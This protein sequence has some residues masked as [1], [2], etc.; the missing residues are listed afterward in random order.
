MPVDAWAPGWFLR[1]GVDGDGVSVGV[2]ERELEAEGSLEWFLRNGHAGF[3]EA[4]VYSGRI[5]V[6]EPHPDPP[7]QWRRIE[8]DAGERF[9]HGEGHSV[10]GGEDDCGRGGDWESFQPDEVFVEASGCRRVA[11]LE[12]DKRGTGGGHGVILLSCRHGVDVKSLTLNCGVCQTIDMKD[13]DQRPK[14][15]ASEE[16]GVLIKQTQA[17]LNQRMD[18]VLRPLGLSV[19]QY[20]CLQALHDSPGI[21]G[22]ELARRVFV[23]RQSTSVLLHG[24]EKRGLIV[25]AEDPGPRRERAMS[26]A[27]HAVA[28]AQHARREVAQIVDAMTAALGAREREQLHRLLTACRDSLTSNPT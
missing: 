10:A 6:V 12:R 28:L 4:L 17:V 25:R 16:L 20:A 3:G 19:A 23:S 18:E 15:T 22:S 5:R 7:A 8:V 9:A 26:L 1:G 21:S 11:D 14:Q 24:L 13:S 27:P 2:T